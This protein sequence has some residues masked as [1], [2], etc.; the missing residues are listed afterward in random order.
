MNENKKDN[1]RAA[2]QMFAAAASL[3]AIARGLYIGDLGADDKVISAPASTNLEAFREQRTPPKHRKLKK[4]RRERLKR[5]SKQK[6]R[7]KA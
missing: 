4:N 2:T 1:L 5:K 7:K 3:G 6:R